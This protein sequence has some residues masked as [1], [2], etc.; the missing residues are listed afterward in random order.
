MFALASDLS[1]HDLLARIC[2]LAGKEREASAELVAH[3]AVLDA[4]PSLY[5]AQGHGSLFSYCTQVLHLSEDAACNRIDAARACSAVSMMLEMLASGE[6]S[7]D[8]G[9]DAASVPHAGESRSRARGVPWPESSRRAGPDRGARA[10]TGR[11]V[12]RPQASDAGADAGV[13]GGI[14]FS[15][16]G[17]TSEPVGAAVPD[18]PSR[19]SR[20][21]PRGGAPSSRRRRQIAI[22]SSSRSARKATSGFA[23]SRPSCAAR[24]RAVT[25]VRSSTG[26]SRCSSSGWR[27]RSSG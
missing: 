20:R 11:A 21:L 12:V 8:V 1:D 7:L 16:S 17:D 18:A 13:S 10:A 26:P 15:E 4:R 3:L 25:L 6:L 2:A 14:A 19:Y 9:A 24:F 22:A 27:N 5:A 23:A